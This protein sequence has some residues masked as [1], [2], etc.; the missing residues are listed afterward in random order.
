MGIQIKTLVLGDGKNFPKRGNTVIV[1]YTGKLEDGARFDSSRDRNEAF[2]FILGA[3]QV[4][5]GWEEGIAQMSKGQLCEMNLTPDYA[6]GV[7][8]FPPSIPGNTSLIFEIEL[9]DFK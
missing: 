2:E 8:G 7:E 5:R 4:I 3:G 1:H 9:I 6:Y